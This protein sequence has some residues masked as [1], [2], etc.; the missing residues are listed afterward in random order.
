MPTSQTRVLVL[1]I[2][3][4][5]EPIVGRLDDE[6][7]AGREF[8]GWLGLARALETLLDAAEGRPANRPPL[9]PSDPCREQ[10]D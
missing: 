2:D 9:S 4:E 10:A 7:G 3:P 1:R 5:A 6:R 8:T